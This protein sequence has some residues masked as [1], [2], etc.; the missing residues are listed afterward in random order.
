M[1]SSRIITAKD[2]MNTTVGM[3]DSSASA[4]DAAKKMIHLNLDFIVVIKNAIPIGI[5]TCRDFVMQII[6]NAYPIY[7]PIEKIISAPLVHCMPEQPVWEV[8]DL[9]YAR[10][11]NKIPVIDE[12]DELLGTVGVVDLLKVFSLQT[13]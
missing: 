6:V 10:G 8:A 2:I 1:E 4:A 13:K 9:M 11:I 3:V 5:I 12:Y 7:M